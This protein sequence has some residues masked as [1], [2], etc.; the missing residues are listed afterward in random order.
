MWYGNNLADESL[1]VIKEK[2]RRVGFL[3]HSIPGKEIFEAQDVSA[4]WVSQEKGCY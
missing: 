1:K 2:R 4:W 3:S